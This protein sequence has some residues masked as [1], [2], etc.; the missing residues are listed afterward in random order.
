MTTYITTEEARKIL[1]IME[2]ETVAGLCA[3]GKLKAYR[4][5]PAKNAPWAI[6]KQSVI[7]YKAQ[8]E[9]RQ[10]WTPIPGQRLAQHYNR[11]TFSYTTKC[12]IQQA[13][14]IADM[15]QHAANERERE[16]FGG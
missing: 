8:R 9:P 3:K 4:T 16:R 12:S 6:D 5:G 15:R 7:E 2:R 13:R 10:V 1:G 11:R 14:A